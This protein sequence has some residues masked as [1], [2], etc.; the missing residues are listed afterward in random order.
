MG[1]HGPSSNYIKKLLEKPMSLIQFTGYLSP[2]SL[3]G[4][5]MNTPTGE[6]FTFPGGHTCIKSANIMQTREL[7]AHGY[8]DVLV[9]FAKQFNH[10]KSIVLHHGESEVKEGFREF[11]RKELGLDNIGILDSETGFII[12]TSGIVSKYSTK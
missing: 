12:T 1:T 2:D 11:L 9:T 7:S 4:K 3:G 6:E 5:I 8:S 10:L